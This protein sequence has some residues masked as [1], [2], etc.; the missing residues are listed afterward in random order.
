MHFWSAGLLELVSSRMKTFLL[1]DEPKEE[2][3][4]EMIQVI[5]IFFSCVMCLQVITN[6]TLHTAS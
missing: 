5:S 2:E 4:A 1:N 3:V 6:H